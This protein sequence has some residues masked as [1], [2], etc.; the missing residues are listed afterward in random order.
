[1]VLCPVAQHA[2]EH[3]E[4]PALIFGD[5][6]WSWS[7]LHRHTSAVTGWLQERGV[8]AGGRVCVVAGNHPGL[9]PL[10]VAA[11]RLGALVVPLNARL[12]AS[13]RTPLLARVQARVTLEDAHLHAALDG[14]PVSMD[15]V[16]PERP[17]TV[18]FTSGTT[19]SPKGAVLSLGNFLASAKANA[20][21]LGGDAAQRWLGTLP[22]FH[23]GGLAMMW[24]C[25]AYGATLVL[26]PRLDVATALQ[27]L[28]HQGITHLSL[29][30]TTLA[31]LLDAMDTRNFPR[32]VRAALIGGGPVSSA[33]VESARSRGLPALQTWGMT[34][35]TSQICTQRLDDLATDHA[36]PPLPGTHV[37]VVDDE[38]KPVPQGQ[39]G[40]LEV[41]GPTVMLGYL[42][43][44][45]G[46]AAAFR[47]DWLRTGDLGSMGT[48]GAVSILSRRADL[49]LRGGEN[50]Y[51][52]EVERVLVQHPAVVEA[53][54]LP[55][56]DEQWGQVPAAFVAWRGEDLEGLQRHTG[57]HLATFKRPVHW[58][59][60]PELPRNAMGKVDR[61]ALLA[62]VGQRR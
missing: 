1:M 14:P 12:T 33:R 4:D 52:T 25:L 39:A 31:R 44:A 16:A 7:D 48:N 15:H 46:T 2:A 60:V 47:V 35:T 55:V 30:P 61:A 26:Q 45:A 28:E 37:R 50:V 58:V 34:E 18:L 19:G 3:G 42:D 20:D 38:S 11:A 53:A 10:H 22:L 43:D 6:T 21:N 59:S 24:R 17:L 5:T 41:R 8:S 57:E 13:E 36:G 51:P 29:V 54:V 27:A 9:V 40:G 56:A 23:V 32:T 62:L 49:I